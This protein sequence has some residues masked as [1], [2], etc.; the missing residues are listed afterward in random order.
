MKTDR[1]QILTATTRALARDK[2]ITISFGTNQ[3]NPAKHTFTAPPLTSELSGKRATAELRGTLDHQAL[4]QRYHNEA[5]HQSLRPSHLQA[6]KIFDALEQARVDSL[7]SACMQGVANNISQLWEKNAALD[8]NQ[9][10]SSQ[11]DDVLAN[12]LGALARQQFADI[13]P[14]VNLQDAVK[15]WQTR[16]DSSSANILQKLAA[17]LNEQNTY[18][19]HV[20]SLL[21]SL[22]IIEEISG[23][24]SLKRDT[25]DQQPEA[26]DNDANKDGEDENDDVQT[27]GLA[28]TG[29]RAETIPPDAMHATTM[30]PLMD[31]IEASAPTDRGTPHNHNTIPHLQYKIFTKKHDE[32]VAATSLASSDELRV[33][34]QQLAQKLL[35]LQATAGRMAHKLQHLLLA[36][37]NREW[38]VDQEEGILDAR[39]LTRAITSPMDQLYFKQEKKSEFK[40]TVVTLLIDNSGSM[41]GRPIT[42]AALSASILGKTL[43]RCGVK[44]EVLGF[45]TCDWK[46]GQA[47][48]DWQSAGKPINPGRL[49]DLRHIVYKSADQPWRKAH[50]SLGL[51]LKEGLLKENIDGEAILWAA[52]RL[53]RRPEERRILMIISDGAPVDDSTLSSNHGSYLD[54]HLREV[55][56]HIENQTPI[57]LLAIGIGHDV[58]RYYKR[59][60]TIS[61]V[62][63][64]PEV[65]G[66]ELLDL[67]K[68]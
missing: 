12:V 25:S 5:K 51:M 16:I 14:P 23:D 4:M 20:V 62:E 39:R 29:E 9:S 55:I 22:D 43:E 3:K 65:M 67:F 10:A 34:N 60:V 30:Q 15:R 17:S 47:A 13:I 1:Q 2:R 59:A 50:N 56:A 52:N 8:L 53:S 21:K 44:V 36:Q 58:T 54:H 63:K 46:G 45:T 32:V 6:G 42:I 68:N 18:A 28:I 24:H 19:E 7:G 66:K 57:E 61:D 26:N 48:R 49:N 41:R 64:L 33:L 35:P 27:E 40:D 38:L 11:Q 31:D 37:Q